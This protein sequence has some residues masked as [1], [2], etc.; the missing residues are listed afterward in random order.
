MISAVRERGATFWLILRF[1]GNSTPIVSEFIVSNSILKSRRKVYKY[2]IK[3]FFFKNLSFNEIDA[4]RFCLIMAACDDVHPQLFHDMVVLVAYFSGD[5][6]VNSRPV[7]LVYV[8]TCPA[9]ND[10]H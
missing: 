9:G 6:G 5:I 3:L 2:C 1:L 8:F 7:C 4:N 10:S